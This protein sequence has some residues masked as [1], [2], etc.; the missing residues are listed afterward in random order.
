[1]SRIAARARAGFIGVTGTGAAASIGLAFLVFTCTFIAAF[2]PRASFAHRTEALQ[3]TFAAAGQLGRSVTATES[4]A[5]SGQLS[6]QVIADYWQPGASTMRSDGLTL[7]RPSGGWAGLTTAP[8]QS[9]NGLD[10]VELAYRSTLASNVRL[11]AGSLPV[12]AVRHKSVWVIQA[13]VTSAAASS[14][15]ARVGTT[16]RMVAGI[17]LTVTA[18]VRPADPAAAFWTYDPT[19]LTYSATG[20][21]GAFIGAGEVSAVQDALQRIAT[22]DGSLLSAASILSWNFPLRLGGITID[23]APALLSQ[24][25][26]VEHT[27]GS[28]SYTTPLASELAAFIAADDGINTVVAFLFVSLTVLGMI[29]VLQGARLLAEHR[30]AEF[31][32]MRARGAS[33]LR[34]CWLALRGGA[35]VAIPAAA[36]AVGAAV[37]VRPGPSTALEW[38]LAALIVAVVVAGVPVSTVLLQLSRRVRRP[39]H[40]PSK[41]AL[42]ARRWVTDVALIVIAVGGLVELRQLGP[43]PAGGLNLFTSAAPAVAALPAA[44]IAMRL[45][46]V[47]L[48]WLLRLTR[49]RRGVALFVG[50][51]RSEQA[52]LS[53]ALPVFALVLALAIVSFGATL[54]AA[55]QRGDVLASWQDVGADAVITGQSGAAL[56]AALQNSVRAVAGVQRTATADLTTGQ[57]DGIASVLMVVLDP[58][59]YGALIAGTAAPAFPAAAL[60]R[61]ASGHTVPVLVSGPAQSLLDGPGNVISVGTRTLNVRVAGVIS[62]LAVEPA[63]SEFVVVPS[64]AVPAAQPNV[65]AVIGPGLDGAALAAVVRHAP[66]PAPALQLR[67]PLVT[68]RTNAPLPRSAYLTSL[69]GLAATVCLS[70]LSL[71]LALVLGAR[72]RALTQARLATMGV[73]RRQARLLGLVESVPAIVV[74]AAGGTACVATLIPLVAPA[75]SLSAFT[76]SNVSAPFLTDPLALA[77][78]AAALIVLAV[79]TIFIQVAVASHRGAARQLRVGE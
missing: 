46:P 36:A 67:S 29:V 14:M 21:A 69:A 58:A 40:A 39:S 9:A 6:G 20:L 79:A 62:A 5:D 17:D 78:S 72:S 70:L 43:P 30:D 75:I 64:W 77:G 37:A 32:V 51:A 52:A 11:V 28:L 34:M 60:A 44:V 8:F 27:T 31:A 68:A 66:A 56:P 61:P 3:Q 4:A 73:S 35:I 48:R 15:H 12:T 2:L 65:M 57:A 10:Q 23:E 25:Q 26:A 38:K 49:R 71:L 18:I 47:L 50:F 22:P 24:V 13:A 63:G 1:M 42:A 16:L 19:L 55:V 59:W 53:T 45:Y 74:A 76:S 41:R 7:A 54:H 33:L